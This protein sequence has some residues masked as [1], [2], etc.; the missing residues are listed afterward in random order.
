MKRQVEENL[1]INEVINLL[2]KEQ[3]VLPEFHLM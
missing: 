1:S 3:I 2:E